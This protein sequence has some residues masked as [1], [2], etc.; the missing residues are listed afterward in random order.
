M[1]YI[2]TREH[3]RLRAKLIH[4]WKPW[5]QSTGPISQK[6]KNKASR[7]AYKGGMRST[8]REISAL[9]KEQRKC[10]LIVLR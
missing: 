8:L 1:S 4:K 6:G 3:R 9:L 10:L 2:R 5:L 7:N